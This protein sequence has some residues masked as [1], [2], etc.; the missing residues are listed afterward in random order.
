MK[1]DICDRILS[2][3]EVSFNRDHDKWEPCGT[4]L[5]IINEVFE[6]HDEEE[7]DRQI[8]EESYYEDLSEEQ[9]KAVEDRYD[10]E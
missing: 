3:E 10:R 8:A 4:C 6:H 9:N 2:P 5:A 1:C 7:I